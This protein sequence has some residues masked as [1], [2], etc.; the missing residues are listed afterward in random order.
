MYRLPVFNTLCF[1]LSQ[2]GTRNYNFQGNISLARRYAEQNIFYGTGMG[3]AQWA[4]LLCPTG[5]PIVAQDQQPVPVSP[6][7]VGWVTPGGITIAYYAIAGHYVGVGFP[8]AHMA[9]LLAPLTPQVIAAVGD[10]QGIGA[11]PSP[12][13]Y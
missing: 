6:D 5:T 12:M 9:F 3:I 8:N 7:Y 11:N 4:W 1:G 2:D 13:P 10:P